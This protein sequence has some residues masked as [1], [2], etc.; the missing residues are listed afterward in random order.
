MPSKEEELLTTRKIVVVILTSLLLSSLACYHR[1]LVNSIEENL[2]VPEMSEENERKMT[3]AS[4][5]VL[6]TVITSVV[7]SLMIPLL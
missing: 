5:V 2:G 3:L 7:A 1:Y 6:I 4:R